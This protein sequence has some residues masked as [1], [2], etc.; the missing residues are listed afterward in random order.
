MELTICLVLTKEQVMAYK[1]L[2]ID[3]I[4]KIL[5]YHNKG[6]PKKK[7]ARLLGLSKNTVK[8]YILRKAEQGQNQEDILVRKNEVL[9]QVSSLVALRESD[10]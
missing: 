3:Q 7:I 2:R 9:S 8:K 6:V 4:Q 1:P 5:E 10:I